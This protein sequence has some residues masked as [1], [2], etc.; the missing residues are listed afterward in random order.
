[1]YR[2]KHPAQIWLMELWVQ[3]G[4]IDAALERKAEWY[5]RGTQITSA[6]D[7]VRVSGGEQRSKVEE[8]GISLADIEADIEN[9]IRTYRAERQA[10][11]E[12]IDALRDPYQKSILRMRYLY[13]WSWRKIVNNLP[14]EETRMFAIHAE[15]LRE[16][17]E[18][19]KE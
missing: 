19:I 4:C 11:I 7:T 8:A 15:A 1:M 12:A 2:E 9:E 3:K 14:Y 10:R 13:H 5:E 6:T 16:I 18:L 17:W